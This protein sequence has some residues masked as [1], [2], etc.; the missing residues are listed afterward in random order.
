MGQYFVGMLHVCE[1]R[2]M[3]V[4]W[5]SVCVWRRRR[6]GVDKTHGQARNVRK[7]LV[8][9]SVWTV[10]QQL[11]WWLFYS[12]LKLMVSIGS[13][14][15]STDVDARSMI[16]IHEIFTKYEWIPHGLPFLGRNSMQISPW[17]TAESRSYARQ[18]YIVMISIIRYKN[19]NCESIRASGDKQYFMACLSRSQFHV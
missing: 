18:L 7:V 10:R 12:S 9:R 4:W 5:R 15:F 3:S 19:T 13:V 11:I 16:L 2:S 6:I 17:D 14:S 1:W 8:R